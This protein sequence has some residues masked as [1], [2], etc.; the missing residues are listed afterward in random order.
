M[1]PLTG[2]WFLKQ[3]PRWRFQLQGP[4]FVLSAFPEDSVHVFIIS[5]PS[6]PEETKTPRC[7]MSLIPGYTMSQVQTH[8]RTEKKQCPRCC[9]RVFCSPVVSRELALSCWVSCGGGWNPGLSFCEEH[10]AL[11]TEAG[12]LADLWD[13]QIVLQTLPGSQLYKSDLDNLLEI[14]VQAVVFITMPCV[15]LK[16]YVLGWCNKI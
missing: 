11:A 1:V 3:E 5:V 2:H 16:V 13:W 12:K 15:K 7:C 8:V 9:L 6:P 4:R 10:L 14:N